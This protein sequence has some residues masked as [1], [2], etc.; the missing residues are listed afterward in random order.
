LPVRVIGK[1]KGFSSDI[2]DGM[3]WAAGLAVEGV[4]RNPHPAQVLNLS[5]GAPVSGISFAG[6]GLCPQS[7]QEAIDEII[8]SGT[9]IV[10]SAGNRSGDAA[11][12]AP[13]NCRGV[14][15]VA[16]TIRGGS[17]ASYSDSGRVVDISAP[18]GQRLTRDDPS[19]ILS[20]LNTGT[21][22]PED[23][24]F[25]Y[26]IGTSQ[27][28]PHVSGVVSLMLS[29]DPELTP[30]QVREALIRSARPFPAGAGCDNFICGAG[31]VDA[32]AAVRA[33]M[34]ASQNIDYFPFAVNNVQGFDS[35]LI[36]TN[37]VASSSSL[38][39][40]T[41]SAILPGE[42]CRFNL[43][44]G[45]YQVKTFQMPEIGLSNAVGQIRIYTLT[46]QPPLAPNLLLFNYN[47]EEFTLIP[48]TR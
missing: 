7:Y 44:L 16:A 21:T 1:C 23:D 31:I 32:E 4:P 45:P 42:R 48:P 24:A 34:L 43:Q 47:A 8:T 10:T 36:V 46:D 38:T 35:L 26:Y 20:T 33:A 3:R 9:V 40:C 17:K 12:S 28:A 2:I 41:T 39:L 14:I 25:G 18:G 22:V 37:L 19:G 30:V 27:A 5:L 11:L 6:S 29:V 15:T 13:G